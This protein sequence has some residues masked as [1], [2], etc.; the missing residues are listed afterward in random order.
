MEAAKSI[1]LGEELRLSVSSSDGTSK[2]LKDQLS[3]M[4]SKLEKLGRDY[5]H[6]EMSRMAL[7]R[8]NAQLQ[9]EVALQKI[10][11]KELKNAWAKDQLL[12]TQLKLKYCDFMPVQTKML[13]SF[14]EKL[15]DE[16]EEE[17]KENKGPL[18]EKNT[19]SSSGNGKAPPPTNRK[20]NAA[21]ISNVPVV[22]AEENV[23]EC[24]AS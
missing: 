2:Y 3:K 18:K 16:N 24:K 6:A 11:I 1:K 15:R 23:G 22:A 20:N 19:S 21:S 12:V 17:L 7:Y 13:P 8:S 9:S 5:D 4:Q 10:S 14:K